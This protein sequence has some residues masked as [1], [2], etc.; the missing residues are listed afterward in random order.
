MDKPISVGDLVMVVRACCSRRVRPLIF[1]V[2]RIDEGTIG[3]ICVD[4][5][6]QM[7]TDSF[8]GPDGPVGQPVSWLK[9][10][11]PLSELEGETTQEDI[12]EPA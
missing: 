10:I 5:G 2:A 8:G 11:P 4:C 7:P 6:A 3:G 1:K 12:R 9:R